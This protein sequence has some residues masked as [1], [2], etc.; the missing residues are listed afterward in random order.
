M[1]I[2]EIISKYLGESAT[3]K[4]SKEREEYKRKKGEHDNIIKKLMKQ[5]SGK[6]DDMKEKHIRAEKKRAEEKWEKWLKNWTKSK[7]KRKSN[8]DDPT[9]DGGND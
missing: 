2:G 3:G 1:K 5:L 4:P 6:I 7:E 8:H 9:Y